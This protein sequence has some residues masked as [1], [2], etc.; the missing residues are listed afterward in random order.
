MTH[1]VFIMLSASLLTMA[2]TKPSQVQNAAQTPQA[3]TPSTSQQS[4]AAQAQA[5][6]LIGHNQLHLRR[7]T[8]AQTNCDAA[9]KLDPANVIAKD[10]LDRVAEMLVDQDLNTAEGKHATGDN[11]AAIDLASKWING[12]YRANQPSYAKD[13]VKRSR[14][15][16]VED[17]FTALTP[18]WLRQALA[19]VA[20]ICAAALILLAIRKLWRE[21]QRGKWYGTST[22][23]NWTMIPLTQ[24]PAVA[25]PQLNLP[26][27]AVLDAINRLGLQLEREL[28]QP[29]LLLLRPTPPAN[30]EPAIISNFCSSSLSD[31]VLAPGAGDLCMEWTL[32]DIQLSQAVQS[33]QFKTSTGIDVGSIARFLNSIVVWFN[34][35]APAISGVAETAADGKFSLHLTARGGRVR[36]MT[37]STSTPSAPG[38]DPVQIS[39][40]RAAYKFL[41]RMRHPW[42]TIE[43]VDGFAALRQG[44]SQF[45]Q[46]AGTI[47]G[48][49]PEACTRTSSLAE[50]AFNFE[51][52]RASIPLHC[53]PPQK[54]SRSQAVK[55][56][57]GK[58]SSAIAPKQLPTPLPV[59]LSDPSSIVSS[60]QPEADGDT[61]PPS[62]QITD[63]VRQA[64]L[65]AEG[66]AH[67]MIGSKA[68]R[69]CAIDC[70]RQL[71][72]W[73]GTEE[74]STLRQQAAY[75][76]AILWGQD[77][78]YPR[79]VLMLTDL[80]GERAPDTVTA[81]SHG[82]LSAEMP[83]SQLGD[84][85]RFPARVAR[86]SAFARYTRDEWSTLPR[87][88]VELLTGDGVRLVTDLK[89]LLD[90]ATS[91][92]DDDER[93]TETS[94]SKQHGISARD[95]RIA[96]YMYIESLRAI[97][98]VELLRV[99]TDAGPAFYQNNRPIGL[100]TGDVSPEARQSLL[101][102]TDWMLICEQSA[103]NYDLYCDLAEA[104]LL[105]KDFPAAQ[106]YARHATLQ[107]LSDT[108]SFADYERAYYLATE[109]FYLQGTDA[110]KAL[111]VKY[112]SDFR[113]Y[114]PIT[115]DEFKSVCAD[116]GLNK[117]PE[118]TVAP[119]PPP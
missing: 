110:S 49:G 38:I 61:R 73:P 102:A 12:G 79:S 101:R 71:Q 96:Q 25:D 8:E 53:A 82:A 4:P 98:H 52:F 100:K 113:A 28:W 43:E 44:A 80:L 86:L 111:A 81:D 2:E 7:L 69:T 54:A 36:A 15:S 34:F 87:A 116:L 48:T 31:I 32:H 92:G 21:W 30:Y 18:A 19:T 108:Q 29:K 3:T 72:D 99:I 112:S 35:G 9:L 89:I 51:F 119:Q 78:N 65:L 37:V 91:Q 75:N 68:D 41:L 62:L 105:L 70:F 55:K 118:Q 24:I 59:P 11:K 97:G 17:L 67:A 104:Y 77:G 107:K 109:S 47:P 83:A 60:S 20:I 64:V 50:A 103:P 6:A 13:I 85:I 84:A 27:D 66:V 57:A 58:A 63:E 10:C 46:Y 114:A 95:Q 115:L 74:T 23:T 39:A 45:V 94:D 88:R 106:G 26:T 1:L 5:L 93:N 117:A 90:S 33:L 42:M 14:P 16:K 76:E 56:S 40:G 22:K